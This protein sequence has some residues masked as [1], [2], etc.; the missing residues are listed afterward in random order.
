MKSRKI[1]WYG[2]IN[3]Y[4][5]ATIC[6]LGMFAVSEPQADASPMQFGV[7]Y[8]D[9]I[10][11]TNP[12]TGNNNAWTTARNAAA[13]SNYNGVNGHLATIS[14]QAENDF[15]IGLV[16]GNYTGFTGAWLGGK[17]PE[18]WLVGPENGQAFI[19]TN[20]AGVEP[21]NAGYIYMSIGTNFG[22]PGQWADDSLVQGVP[23]F[24]ND[25]VIGYFVE[26]ENAAPVP[27]PATMLLLGTGLV[28]VAGAARRRKKNQA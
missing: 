13:A 19:Y 17:A 7:N 11:V 22:T 2:A 26:Y 8:Y 23:S 3:K 6:M 27:E 25:P 18:G 28:G 5:V 9:F 15:L 20:W 4:L 1:L 14:S 21:N 16:S 24:P 10:E 12:Y